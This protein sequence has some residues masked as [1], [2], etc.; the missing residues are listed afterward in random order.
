VIDKTGTLT[1][2]RPR[3]VTVKT[4]RGG[5]ET[6]LLRYAASLERGSEHPLAAAIV[7]GAEARH[8]VTT[9]AT[10][11]ES[12]TGKGA[13]GHVDGCRVAVGNL[14]LMRDRGA[15]NE[16]LTQVAEQLRAEGQTVMFVA[17]EGRI[18]GLLGVVDPIKESTAEA[19]FALHEAGI[20]V[21]MQRADTRTSG[22]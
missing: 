22:G 8:I 17:L 7:A 11:F 21:A 6:M 4:E 16:Q 18:A 20:H 15:E 12:V 1:E 9:T 10:E 5:D 13:L 19:I 3:L 14:A 2:G